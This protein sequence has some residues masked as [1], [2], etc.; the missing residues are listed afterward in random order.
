MLIIEWKW[1]KQNHPII[2][3]TVQL[4]MGTMYSANADLNGLLESSGSAGSLT[5]SKAIHKV[6][7][8]VNESGSEAGAVTSKAH[9][10]GMT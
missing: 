9:S 10:N 4:N 8:N 6:F 2:F 3:D 5:V 1:L 7:I